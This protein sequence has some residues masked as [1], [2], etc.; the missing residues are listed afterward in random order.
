M[1]YVKCE[2]CKCVIPSYLAYETGELSEDVHREPLYSCR[3]CI[4]EEDD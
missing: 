4:E 1:S 2:Y 3:D